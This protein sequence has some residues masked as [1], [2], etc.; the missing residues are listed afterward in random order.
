MA[1]S[2]FLVMKESLL[3]RV[4][5][6]NIN[7]LFQKLSVDLEEHYINNLHAIS[8]GS[9]DIFCSHRYAGK[10]L[11]KGELGFRKPLLDENNSV[12]FHWMTAILLYQVLL[13][14]A[15]FIM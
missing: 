12:Q 1:E 5:E 3:Q 7:A 4:K 10:F 8:S 9:N 13:Y 6:Y 15:K 14:R 2:Q 11:K